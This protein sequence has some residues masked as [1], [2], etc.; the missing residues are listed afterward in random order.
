MAAAVTAREYENNPSRLPR[1]QDSVEDGK[2]ERNI[3]IVYS[4]ELRES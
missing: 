2:L 1:K 4:G 3:E